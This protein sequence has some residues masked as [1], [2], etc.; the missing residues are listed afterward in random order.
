MNKLITEILQKIKPEIFEDYSEDVRQDYYKELN[1][2]IQSY[3]DDRIQES[4][5]PF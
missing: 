3:V 5:I 2:L 4:K 1:S